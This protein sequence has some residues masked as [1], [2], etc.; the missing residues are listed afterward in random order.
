MGYQL[1][2]ISDAWNIFDGLIVIISLIDI[3]LPTE[4]DINNAYIIY[5]IKFECLSITKK[6]TT[7]FENFIYEKC[8]VNNKSLKICNRENEMDEVNN[9]NILKME[10]KDN[11]IR[12]LQ[13]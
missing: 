12:N 10:G 6:N 9:K 11:L 1:L 13:F 4:M 2:Y 5:L 8:N 3:C 7:K